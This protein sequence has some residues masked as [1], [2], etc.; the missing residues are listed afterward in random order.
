MKSI[1]IILILLIF[2]P[3]EEYR[4]TTFVFPAYKHTYG[5]RKAGPTA[6]FMLMGFRVKFRDP[7]GLACVRL[8]SWEDPDDPHD[9]DEVIS[10]V[11]LGKAGQGVNGVGGSG[12]VEFNV[13]HTKALILSKGPVDQLEAVVVGQKGFPFLERVMR[14]D[15]EP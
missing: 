4:P 8:D 10:R 2:I 15:H 13:G 9:D 5:I 7:Q 14:W 6:L 11:L 12:H 1:I 3:E